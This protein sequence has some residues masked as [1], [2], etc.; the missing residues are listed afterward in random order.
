MFRVMRS[1]S[2]RPPSPKAEDTTMKANSGEVCIPVAAVAL[3]GGGDQTAAVNPAPGDPVE[4]QAT[5]TVT[6]IEGGNAYV[7]LDT[8]NGQPIVKDGMGESM[9]VDDELAQME[10]DIT[11]SETPEY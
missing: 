7:K 5:G 3:P 11:Q 2:P 9:S 6:R 4:F 10:A 1:S 8:A